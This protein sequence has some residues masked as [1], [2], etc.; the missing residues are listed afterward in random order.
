MSDFPVSPDS[1]PL[2]AEKKSKRI[3]TIPEQGT[4]LPD[5][6]RLPRPKP[7]NDGDED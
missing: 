3:I 4:P 2:P 1:S 7:N 6:I 5:K